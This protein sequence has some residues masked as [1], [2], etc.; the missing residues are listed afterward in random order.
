MAEDYSKGMVKY[1]SRDYESLMEDF[2]SIVPKMTELW[3]P[4]ADADPGVVLGKFLVNVADMLGVNT[5]WLANEMFAPSVS[6]RKNAER[7][8]SLIGYELGWYTAARTEVTFTNTGEH[9]SVTLDFGFNGSNFCT[10]NAYTDITNQARVITYNILPLTNKYGSKD[11]RS[12][13]TIITELVNV[14]ADTDEV[15]LAEGESVTRVAIEGELRSYSIS[16]AQIKKNNYIINIPSQHIDTTAIWIKAR[17]SQNDDDFLTTQWVQVSSPADFITPEPRFAVTYDS[18]SNAQIQISNYLNQLENYENNYLTVYWIDCS[19]IIGCVGT[20]VLTNFLPAK[21]PDAA[22][23]LG[24]YITISNLSNTLELPNTHAVTG[25]SPETAKE[26]YYNS[27]KYIN[28]FDSLVTLPDFNRFL[29]REPGVDCGLVID[30]QKALELNLAVY[31]D[32]NLTDDQKQKMYITNYDFPKGDPA[33]D[34]TPMLN[35]DFTTVRAY[36]VVQP[37]QTLEDISNYYE[38]TIDDLMK[39]NKFIS[40]DEISAGM[41]IKIPGEYNRSL[42]QSLVS[43]FK[44]YTAM[45]FC[46][47]NDFKSSSWG[48]GKIATP[49]IKNKKIFY[50]YKPPVQFI[51]AVRKDYRPLQAMSVEL[52]FGYLRI[53]PFY[54]IGQIYP[55]RPVSRDVGENIIAK[56][57][58]A[59]ALYFAPANRHIGEKPTVMEVV[60]VIRNA[61]SRIDYFDAGSLKNPV[62]QYYDCDPSYFNAISF[63]RYLPIGSTNDIRISPEYLV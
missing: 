34:W 5:D 17:A 6:Q 33:I 43:N 27:R 52:E 1:T 32:Q 62:I 63:S 55:K 15:T 3:K 4:E 37:N 29:N 51:D 38:V 49:Q 50:T 7:I 61:D 14:F 46:I 9:G 58:E 19:G 44:T 10:L 57:K 54:I 30:C 31:N 18:Y 59:L 22:E 2:W 45:C 16:V 8:F 20:D 41:R 56:V 21:N 47:H 39:I 13:R 48:N 24:D 25:K 42:A 36:H 12:R 53:F 40:E 35:F 23:G 26:A 11:T 28:T 60:N